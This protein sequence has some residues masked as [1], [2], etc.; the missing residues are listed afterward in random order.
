MLWKKRSDNGAVLR[1]DNGIDYSKCDN[2]G[3]CATVCPKKLIKDSKVET[4]DDPV[5]QPK[6]S[7]VI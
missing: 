2:C 3:L 5:V 6:N 7:P 4:L 1:L